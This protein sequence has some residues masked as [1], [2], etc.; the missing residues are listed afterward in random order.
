MALSVTKLRREFEVRIW[1]K[2][3]EQNPYVAV[4]QITGGRAWGRSNLKAR[5]LGE[6]LGSDDVGVRYAI[7]KS[8]REAAT[9]TRFD[10]LGVLF[11]AGGSAVIYGQ[12][13]GPVVEVVKRARRTIDGGILIGGRFGEN[14]V[15]ARVWEMVLESDGEE[16][17][18]AK[19]FSVLSRRPPIV[20]VLERNSAGLVDALRE[21]SRAQRLSNILN[22]MGE[23]E[24]VR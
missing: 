8:A 24:G 7:P 17:E 2:I 6:Q 4:V 18:W 13:I 10:S 19:L 15:T 5:I 1:A 20:D 21:G 12:K 11:R 9:R 22:R 16:A 14:I 23:G 3:I